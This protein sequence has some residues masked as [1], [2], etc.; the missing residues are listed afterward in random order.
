LNQQ[1]EHTYLNQLG[2][3]F[4]RKSDYYSALTYYQQALEIEPQSPVIITNLAQTKFDLDNVESSL[5]DLEKALIL[6]PELGSALKLL[7]DIRTRQKKYEEAKQA[8]LKAFSSDTSNITYALKAAHAYYLTDNPDSSLVLYEKALIIGEI[9]D[10]YKNKRAMSFYKL[11]KYDSAY[12]EFDRLVDKYPDFRDAKVNRAYS[13]AKL[14]RSDEAIVAFEELI[15]LD[16]TNAEFSN[17]L[18]L[19]HFRN[20]FF[21]EAIPYFVQASEKNPRQPVY[22]DNIGHSYYNLMKFTQ[23]VEAY[24]QSL[25]V[26]PEDGYIY[27]RR[28][29]SKAA[30]NDTFDA[31]KDFKK[32]IDLGHEAAEAQ[33]NEHCSFLDN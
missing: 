29:L 7:G 11:G 17:Q 12:K 9:P 26:Y 18:G 15:E 1:M 3:A 23:A 21:E 10:T 33:F 32:A 6:N 4:Y 14:N 13:L 20:E 31:C 25:T 28:G 27:F 5:T 30:L 2:N 22:F 19:I 16:S 24:D 8:Y